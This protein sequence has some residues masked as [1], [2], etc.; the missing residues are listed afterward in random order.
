MP[1]RNGKEL[2]PQTN[3]GARIVHLFEPHPA[4][5]Q[6]PPV[7][8]G[9]VRAVGIVEDRQ[10]VAGHAVVRRR[11]EIRWPQAF[12][13]PG[14]RRNGSEPN[15]EPALIEHDRRAARVTTVG[16]APAAVHRPP[17]CLLDS[18]LPNIDPVDR[19]GF[20]GRSGSIVW[21]GLPPSEGLVGRP[22]GSRPG[23][24]TFG[25]GATE[26]RHRRQRRNHRAAKAPPPARPRD[27]ASSAPGTPG[28]V[29]RPSQGARPPWISWQASMSW[30]ASS[31]SALCSPSRP[32]WTSSPDSCSDV[33]IS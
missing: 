4:P 29:R 14:A 19:R 5:L 8:P 15:E 32:D 11:R 21:V 10:A 20:S 24:G 26:S 6:R 30:D 18:Y 9:R 7:D 27:V 16:G 12:R 31:S 2:G 17:A 25:A 3:I 13:A 22:I 33:P 1:G 28:Q 23:A